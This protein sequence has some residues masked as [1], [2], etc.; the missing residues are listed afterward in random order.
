[1]ARAKKADVSQ[2]SRQHTIYKNAAGVRLPGIT[3]LVG[4]RDKPALAP[5]A[6]KLGL[7]GIDSVAHWKELAVIGRAT[8]AMV[9]AELSGTKFDPKDYTPRQ[10]DRAENGF[11][12]F[13][14]WLKGH[15]LEPIILDNPRLRR[16]QW[17]GRW[18]IAAR[19][20]LELIDAKSGRDL[21]NIGSS[22]PL[23]HH[24]RNTAIRSRPGGSSTSADETETPREVRRQPKEDEVWILTLPRMARE[25]APAEKD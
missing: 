4:L 11:I 18:R 23:H 9:F 3:T 25:A 2:H 20:P 16:H 22:S 10:I 21:R 17:G 12:K 1:M 6:N 24:S 8:H 5:A 19:R 7:Q 13:L 15:K 14:D